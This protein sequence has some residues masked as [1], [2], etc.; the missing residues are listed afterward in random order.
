MENIIAIDSKLPSENEVKKRIQDYL[1]AGNFNMTQIAKEAGMSRSTLSLIMAGDYAGDTKNMMDKLGRWLRLREEKEAAP[2]SNPGFVMTATAQLII[3]DI[4]FSQVAAEDGIV[5]IYGAPGVGKSQALRYYKKNN[6][7]IWMIM[8]CP[9]LS[10]VTAFLYELALEIGINNPPKRKDALSR[11]IRRYLMGT[12]GVLIIDEA[13]HMS[14]EALEEIR[15]IQEQTQFAVVL[16]GNKKTYAKLTGGQRSE[17][18]AQL[19]SRV[20][21]RRG[22]HTTRKADVKAI[23]DA[24]GVHGV[25]E[26]KLMQQIAEKQGR[27]RLLSKTLKLASMYAEGGVITEKTLRAAFNELEGDE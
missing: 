8:A 16:S 15:I 20:A 4:T 12:E 14:Y 17:D 22:I 1:D 27:L 5:M 21:K 2:N 24:W 6:N 25:V 18:F 23:A 10:S 26:R 9:S 3:N 13:Q 7:N 11:S 19:F